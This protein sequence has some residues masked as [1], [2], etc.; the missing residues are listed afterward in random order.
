MHEMYAFKIMYEKII[1]K[2]YAC[3]FGLKTIFEKTKY[4]KMKWNVKK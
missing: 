1:I 2:K 3:E 4:K